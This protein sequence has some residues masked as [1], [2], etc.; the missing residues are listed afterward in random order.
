MWPGVLFAVWAPSAE[1]VS[2]VGNFNRWDGR[3]PPHAG[4]R[5]QRRGLFIPNVGPGDLY[6]FEIRNHQ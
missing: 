6:K 1:R 3:D 2:V 5:R 4:T